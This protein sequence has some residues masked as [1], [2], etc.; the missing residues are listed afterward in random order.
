[1]WNVGTADTKQIEVYVPQMN[2][3][4]PGTG[5]TKKS[6]FLTYGAEPFAGTVSAY[7]GTLGHPG[8]PANLAAESLEIRRVLK[9]TK[10]M[11][12]INLSKEL[13]NGSG[14][15]KSSVPPA[16]FLPSNT[17]KKVI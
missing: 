15:E 5:T 4:L 1:M 6:S 12:A 8:R 17:T 14:S 9:R 13:G 2:H 16:L 7:T 11:P 10:R 3:H